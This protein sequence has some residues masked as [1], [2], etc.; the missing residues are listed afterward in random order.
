MIAIIICVEIAGVWND[1]VCN[2]KQSNI[3]Y[4]NTDGFHEQMVITLHYGIQ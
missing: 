3:S 1:L 2:E 4:A